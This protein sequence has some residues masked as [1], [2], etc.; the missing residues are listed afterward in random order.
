LLIHA[1][2]DSFL[3][4]LEAPI[5]YSKESNLIAIGHNKV[6]LLQHFF[7][8]FVGQRIIL[9]SAFIHLLGQV[10]ISLILVQLGLQSI[11]SK[12]DPLIL[13]KDT[14]SQLLLSFLWPCL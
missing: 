11:E 9:N 7:C 4:K 13:L 1:T 10:N 12:M 6:R 5:I 2:L 8:L 3:E 14:V